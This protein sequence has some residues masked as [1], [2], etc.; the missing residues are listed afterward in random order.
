MLG[1]ALLLMANFG[2]DCVAQ[3]TSMRDP[4]QG[5]RLYCLGKDGLAIRGYS[6]V[7]YFDHEKAEKGSSEF[8]VEHRGITYHFTDAGQVE[9]FNADPDKYE[10]AHGGWCS[11]MMSAS[12][13]RT[14]ANPESFKIVDGRLLLFWHGKYRG[15][16]VDGLANWNK[17][18]NVPANETKGLGR[19]DKN[20][21][22]ITAGKKRS[23]IRVF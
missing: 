20:W 2:A 4:R 15:K 3:G 9:R 6:P 17:R 16:T 18:Y 21:S 19:A 11:L 22:L 12:G 10:P 1:L 5:R 8:A 13:H 14:E 23:P 7:S